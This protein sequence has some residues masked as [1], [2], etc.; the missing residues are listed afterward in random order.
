MSKLICSCLLLLLLVA[1]EHAWGQIGASISTA[2]RAPI[3]TTAFQGGMTPV[4]PA[5][6]QGGVVIQPNPQGVY[7]GGMVQPQ[8]FDPFTTHPQSADI[9][10]QL[11]P[12]PQGFSQPYQAQPYGQAPG[13][14]TPG[15]PQQPPVLYPNGFGYDPACQGWGPGAALAQ[16]TQGPYLRLFQDVRLTY[17]WLGGD[18]GSNNA[19]LAIND[20]EIATTVN[21]PNFLWSNQ[22]LRLSPGFVFHSWAG[23][24]NVAADLPS[25]AYS[26]YLNAYWTTSLDRNVGAE[27]DV[28]AGVFSDFNTITSDSVRIFGTGLGW[29]RITPTLTA[30]AG[31]QYLDRVDLKLLP[32]GGL[33][34]RP[35]QDFYL[36]AYFPRPRVGQRLTYFGNYDVW[37][38]L[39]AE[40][41]GGSWT[42]ERTAGAS[43]RVDI[44]DIRLFVG[45]EWT[46]QVT[47]FSG[48]IEGGYVFNRELVYDRD[49]ASDMNLNDTFMVRGGLVY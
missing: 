37:A 27:F 24:A 38:Y 9:P 10:P 1:P 34:W 20:A 25:K 29:V 19:D 36:E 18:P 17:T 16:P 42:V 43:Q 3:N 44:N 6:V 32:A 35:N 11:M 45:L 46:G 12:P 8:Q 47:P 48:F 23:P 7:G 21:F 41:G 15:Y 2:S 39:G 31:V 13:Y 28:T 5:G 22:P 49:P 26:A 30:K 14:V 40:Y 4:P 33:F